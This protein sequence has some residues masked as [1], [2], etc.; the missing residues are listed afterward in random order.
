MFDVSGLCN[1]GSAV[2]VNTRYGIKFLR[3]ASISPE[4]WD[5][6]KQH[7]EQLKNDGVSV[8]KIDEKWYA[9]W[10]SDKL[11]EIDSSVNNKICDDT[12]KKSQSTNSNFK[13]PCPKNL[14]FYPYQKAGTEFALTRKNTLIADE[15][16]LGKAQ[17]YYS[18]ILTPNGWSSF[19]KINPNDDII[20]SDGHVHKII[21]K[22]DR[23]IRDIYRIYF[24]DN[25]YTDCCDEH[26]WSIN[27]TTR[28]YRKNK[29]LV[30]PLHE[31]KD[32]LFLK[33]G[34]YK[35]FI[36]ITNPVQFDKKELKLD[37]YFLGLLLGDGGIKCRVIFS[38]IDAELINYIKSVLPSNLSV[39]KIPGDN[40]DYRICSSKRGEPN[41]VIRTLKELK[42][43]GKGSYN[44]FIPNEYLFSCIEDRLSI[45]QGLM[46]SDGYVNEDGSHISFSSSSIQLIEGVKFIVQSLGGTAKVKSKNQ[47]HYN[48]K[49][50]LPNEFKP[51]K[52]KRKLNRNVDR[53]KYKP[54]R[55]IKNIEYIGKEQCYC[56]SVD[57][58]D[59]LYLTDEFILTHNT[60]QA[61]G[62]INYDDSI[63][64]IL[65]VCP[66]SLKINWKRELDV[67]LVKKHKVSIIE[68]K[69]WQD[70]DI[71][72]INYDILKNFKEKLTK[73]QWDLFILDEAHMC[74]NKKSIRS[75][76]SL[77]IKAK[78]KIFLTGTPIVNRPSELFY[79]IKSLDNKNWSNY[80]NFAERY[81]NRHFNGFG[82]DDSGARRLDELQ[83]IL[84]SSIM[85]RRLKQD[86][87]K[88]LPDKFRQ[89]IEISSS[90]LE[91][92]LE[93]EKNL[94][95]K[96]EE[97]KGNLNKL[98][99]KSDLTKTTKELA[100][101]ISPL[102]EKNV[103][104]GELAKV[105]KE[106]AIAKVPYIIEY[107]K[108]V[109]DDNDNKII[110]FV[111]HR[112]VVDL[113]MKNL[114]QFNPVKV[115][116]GISS[117]ERQKAIDSFQSDK[118]VRLFIGNIL[119]AGTGLTL[120]A[121]SHVIF[122]E[123]DWV[124]ANMCQ[125]EDRVHRIGQKN[126]VLIQHLVLE[127]S[128]DANIAK[129]L[130]QK[131]KIFEEA[132]NQSDT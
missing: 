79:I 107:I 102:K 84:R 88:E 70:G 125:A 34:N 18:K 42:L 111:H 55:A 38:T 87:L 64:K 82:W 132:L 74:K 26:L 129:T 7:K 86:V 122:G 83:A 3:K 113:L 35:W 52:L 92:I 121:C 120:T 75:K 25:T 41:N 48:L 91:K 108:D 118:T 93:K 109:M 40:C 67:W 16:G 116:G 14:E 47:I 21:N 76:I 8:K 104:F 1:W 9:E 24:T 127:N 13:V 50:Q 80:T 36:P 56:I 96:C 53:V 112:E 99:D 17:P 71:I 130:I 45:L 19:D 117:A 49:I 62:V 89:V 123:L 32:D 65:I 2:K 51:F 6:W 119:A 81:C 33:N 68:G 126:S 58:D 11:V 115:V 97:L 106:V 12:I 114:K 44:K 15:M 61:I 39:K 85:I 98:S 4:F 30:K 22:Y 69:I 105:R 54:S 27:T 20:G 57:C 10:W 31:I 37:P 100:E 60:V 103:A 43:L 131:Q 72:I 77:S 110:L 66:A 78:R 95:K 59:H 63:K 28:N 5:I 124:P 46:D 94:F 90:G 101:A 73:I 128:L 23:G 29:H